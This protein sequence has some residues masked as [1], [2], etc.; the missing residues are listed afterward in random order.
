MEDNRTTYKIPIFDGR[1][2]KNWE[3]SV[4]I[5]LGEKDLKIFIDEYLCY[6]GEDNS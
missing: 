5:L 2:F 4:V 6:L 3:Y 1:D